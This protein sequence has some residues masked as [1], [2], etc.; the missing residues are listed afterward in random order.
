MA[1]ELPAGDC[2]GLVGINGAGKS[3]LLALL[4]GVLLQDRGSITGTAGAAYLPEGCPLDPGIKVKHWLGLA[5]SLP[6][7]ELEIGQQLQADFELPLGKPVQRLSQ[8]QRVRLGLVLTLGRKAPV[9]LLDDPF[10]GLDPV[11]RRLAE[12]WIA[13]RGAESTTVLAAQDSAAV[14]R[15]CTHLLLLDRGRMRLCAPLEEIQRRFRL[16]QVLGGA[17]AAGALG[18]KILSRQQRGELLE[19][20]LDDPQEQAEALLAAAGAQPSPLPLPL[21][22]LLT[23]LVQAE[24]AAS[25]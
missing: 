23:A 18:D 15:L 4:A 10:L 24:R 3:T 11:G 19:L 16:I 14:E 20:L 13:H 5:R 8:G 17:D 21:D 12:K 9:Y 1:F 7:W 6:G 22:E 25:S 2:L